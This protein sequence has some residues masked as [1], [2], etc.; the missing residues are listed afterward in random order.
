MT[1]DLKLNRPATYDHLKSMKKPNRRRIWI[2][3]DSDVAEEYEAAKTARDVAKIRHDAR[4]GDTHAS[5]EYVAAVERFEEVEAQLRENSVLFVFK[6]IGRPKYE[7]LARSFPPT[8]AQR[9]EVE[10]RGGDPKQLPWNTDLFPP[11]LIA[12]SCESPKMTQE[13]ATQLW[14]DD[15][16]WNAAELQVLFETALA[17]NNSRR[18]VELGNA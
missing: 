12:A 17:A 6:S 18:I 3:L 5:E 7:K 14:N 1:Q 15:E 9:D 4:P 2:A 11:A 8:Q 10:D 16:N 13:E